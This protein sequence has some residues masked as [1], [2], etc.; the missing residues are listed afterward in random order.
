MTKEIKAKFVRPVAVVL[1][2]VP[3]VFQTRPCPGMILIKE[4]VV[5]LACLPDS[6]STGSSPNDCMSLLIFQCYYSQSSRNKVHCISRCLPGKIRLLPCFFGTP[7]S[8]RRRRARHPRCHSRKGLKHLLHPPRN[9][10]R[11]RRP[12]HLLHQNPPHNW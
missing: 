2:A 12:R 10:R 8:F 3:S 1:L 9:L 5:R 6:D 7:H 4:I 11:L